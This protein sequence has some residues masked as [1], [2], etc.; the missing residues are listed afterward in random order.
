MDEKKLYYSIREVAQMFNLNDSTLRY[1]EKEFPIINPRK[2]EKGTR[3]YKEEDIEA[4]RVV[5][6]LLKEQGL[7]LAGA[8]KKLRENKEGVIRQV[9]I[10][11]RLK[12]I[13]TELLQLKEAFDLIDSRGSAPET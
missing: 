1:W 11:N 12:H 6:Y 10:V 4:V 8:R 9:E 13:K 3:F 2:N 5:H 7:T